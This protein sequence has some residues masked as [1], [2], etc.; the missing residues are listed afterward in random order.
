MTKHD[1]ANHAEYD[2]I[3]VGVGGMG[4]AATHYLASRGVDVLGLERYDIPHTMGSSHGVTRII[5][6][7]YHEHPD[8][9]PL[10]E[11]AYELWRDLERQHDQ[12]LLYS[13]GSLAL[14]RPDSETV[15][16]A[17]EACQTHSLEYEGL[18]AAEVNE[19]FPG[20]DLPDD[21]VGVYQ[22]EGGLLWSEQCIVAHVNA[23]H[24]E[25][26]TIHA[27]ERVTDWEAT[28]ELV[29]VV[30]DRDTYTAEK[31]V[32]AAG[33][34]APTMLPELADVLQPQRQVLGWFQP[35]TPRNFQPES[36]PVYIVERDE[37]DLYYGFPQFHVPG[38]K[39]GKHYHFGEDVDPDEMAREPRNKDEAALREWVAQGLSS[40]NGPS[41]ALSTCLYTN[42]P[43]KEFIIDHHP[44][45]DNVVVACGFSGH[46]FKFSSVVG[47]I[48]ADLAV[49]GE[50]DHPIDRFACDRF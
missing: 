41:M 2:V 43:D 16:G 15:T 12:Q 8:Y 13:H 10:L 20:F 48:L 33:A 49:E 46:G 50:T 18:D 23:T 4:S 5:R 9:V 29:R 1:S 36:F 28:D 30:T 26:G 3:V 47:E 44:T 22:S 38:V 34:W 21:F 32:V 6:K 24:R 31:L 17:K 7:A 25:G 40:A 19:R 37:D 35:T 45:Y 14:G 11:R 39:V 42:T 27:R